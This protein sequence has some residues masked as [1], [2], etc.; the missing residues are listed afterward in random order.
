MDGGGGVNAMNPYLAGPYAPVTTEVE[1]VDLPVI[2]E[3]PRDLRGLY[4]R[5]GPN[6]ERAPGA[7][8]HWFDGDGMLHALWFENGKVRYRN[9]YV[10]TPDLAAERAGALDAAGI[11]TPANRS[12]AGNRVYK[13]TANTDVIVHGG[14][15]YALWYISGVPIAV[16]PNTLETIRAD[17]F[18]GKLPRN[19]SAHSKTDPETGELVFFDYALYEPWMSVGAISAAG[20]LDW[21]TQVPLPGPRLPHDMGLTAKHVVLMDLPVV[22]TDAAIRRGTWNIRTADQPTRF[23]VLA[24]GASGETTRWFDVPSCYVYHVI[25]AWDDGDAVV[26]A[27]CKMVPNGLNPDPAL[28]GAFAPMVGVLALHAVPILWRFDLKTGAVTETQLNDRITE[29]PVVNLDKTG[30]RTKHGYLV[31]MAPGDLQKFDALTKLDLETGRDVAHVF[32]KGV[33]GSE[34]AFA[35]RE[36][37]TAE[38]DGYVITIVTEEATGKSEALVIDARNFDAPP[39]ARIALPQR[40][41]LGFHATWARADQIGQDLQRGRPAA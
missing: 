16:D 21:F 30:R 32:P 29:F 10:G 22:F 38:D 5:N 27:A 26:M 36:G 28:Y 1:G 20:T 7:P 19:M 41:P 23:G 2:G 6:P 24:R 15:L 9:R 18:S 33:Y 13:D 37:A 31:S 40:V 25:N 12:R 17:T 39:L 11:F 34:P 3:V 35:P 8:H 4:V 14:K